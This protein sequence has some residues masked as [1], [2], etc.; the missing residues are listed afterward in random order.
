MTPFDGKNPTSYMIAI[1]I[2]A[3]SLTVYYIFA[4]QETFKNFDI[5]NEGQAQGVEKWDLRHSTI[6]V[7]IHIGD[8]YQN[9]C[10][11]ATYVYLK[12][13]TYGRRHA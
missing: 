1:V 5:E 4:N 10:Y 12:R 2:F 8:F 11:L 6:N 9:L 3:P 13:Y 7:R